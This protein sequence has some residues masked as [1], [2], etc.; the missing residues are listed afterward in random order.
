VISGGK[1]KHKMHKVNKKTAKKVLFLPAL[2]AVER[3]GIHF[4]V[5]ARPAEQAAA[6]FYT[7]F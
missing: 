4:V 2:G 3:A 5:I 7:L 1:K 6:I